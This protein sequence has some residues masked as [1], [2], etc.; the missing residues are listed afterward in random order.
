[1]EI[2]QKIKQYLGYELSGNGRYY[3]HEHYHWVP[4]EDYENDLNEMHKAEMKLPEGLWDLYLDNLLKVVE[5]GPSGK[6]C[7]VIFA[8]CATAKERAQAFIKTIERT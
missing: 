3:Y 1:M 4:L 8:V 2:S 7:N 5:D 6:N